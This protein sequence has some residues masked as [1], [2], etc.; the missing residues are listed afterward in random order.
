MAK[1]IQA[2]DLRGERRE[3]LIDVVPLPAPWTLFI[4]PC[5]ACNYRCK[6]CPTG[7]P[8]LLR[9]Y[10][11]KNVL[12]SY[13]LFCKIVDDL[14]EFD[15]PC[16]QANLYKDGEPTLHPRFTDMVRY[17]KDA[18]VSERI[19][20]KTNGH[21][22]RPELNAKLVTCGLDMIG[23]S[24]TGINAQMFYDI[25]GVKVDYEKF[26]DGVLDLFER[27]RDT[28][29]RVSTKIADVGLTDGDKQKFLDDFSDRC[30]FIAIENLHGWSTSD[31]FDWKLGTNQSF[32]GTP[33]TQKIACPLVLY[34]LAINSNGD[35]SIC[36]DDQ[37]H[38]HQLGNIKNES[39]YQIWNGTRLRDFRLMHLEG[40]RSENRAC[41]TCDYIQA[42]PDSIDN[43]REE[44]AERIQK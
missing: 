27:S 29:T 32:D 34:M 6:F 44:F 14:R 21:V 12:M 36:N 25:A 30:D 9:E 31:K 4:D 17:M 39:L 15:R 11:R 43:D 33:R 20:V 38:L 13:E 42:L 35:I 10:G 26:R 5:N 7:H 8:D 22:L 19:W 28:S 3:R 23:V 41:G 24:V 37:Y 1:L 16:K 2:K 18:N 40:R